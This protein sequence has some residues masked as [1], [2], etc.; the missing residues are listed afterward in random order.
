MTKLIPAMEVTWRA[1][2]RQLH[3]AFINTASSTGE[4]TMA[5]KTAPTTP[6]MTRRQTRCWTLRIIPISSY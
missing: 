1:K 3:R 6:P 5:T 2:P 4:D